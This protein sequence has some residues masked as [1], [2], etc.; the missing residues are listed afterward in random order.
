MF[1]HAR[2]AK[3]TIAFIPASLIVQGQGLARVAATGVH[4]EI[5]RIGKALQTIQTGQTPLSS[6]RPPVK[7][8]AIGALGLAALVAVVYGLTHGN[9]LDG[10]LAGIALAMALLPEE[11]PVVLT[12]FLALGAWRISQRNVLTAACRR[13]RRSGRRPCCAST[14]RAR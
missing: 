5:G 2:G 4:T 11:F 14:R 7:R 12:V 6:T 9:W 3:T 1:L 8:V 13:S 10:A